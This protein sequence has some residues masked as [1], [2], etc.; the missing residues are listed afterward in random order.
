MPVYRP[1]PMTLTP[2]SSS[3]APKPA[4]PYSQAIRAGDLLF[5]AGQL[6][7]SPDGVL[8][9]EGDIRAQT[10]AVLANIGAILEAAGSSMQQV[11][12]TTVFLTD[13]ADFGGMNEAYAEAF[14]APYPAR[15]TVGIGRLPPGMLVE[16]DCIALA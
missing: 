13:L 5:V 7:L 16:I 11:A 6:P 1:I 9:G 2:V 15:S 14:S 3:D 10:R 8:V 12:K 4:G